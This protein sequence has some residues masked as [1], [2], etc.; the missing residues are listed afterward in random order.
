[1]YDVITSAQEK[2]LPEKTVRFNKYKHK[3]SPWMTNGIL[4][5]IKFRDKLYHT[6]KK[7]KPD[8]LEHEFHKNNLKTYDKILNKTIS[9]A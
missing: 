1:M 6:F 8:S 7:C 9:Q 4:Q 3:C 2:H 5:S